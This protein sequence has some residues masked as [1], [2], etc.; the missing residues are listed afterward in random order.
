[1]SS[2]PQTHHLERTVVSAFT[3]PA[4]EALPANTPARVVFG[5]N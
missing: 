1:M 3:G 4:T 5:S 2:K